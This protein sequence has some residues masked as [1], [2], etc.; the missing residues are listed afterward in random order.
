MAYR[1]Q[2]RRS[3]DQCH[4]KKQRCNWTTGAFQCERCI[5]LHLVCQK[6]RL[7]RKTY[8]QRRGPQ[9][10]AQ[11]SR[12]PARPA[13][14]AS[15]DHTSPESS[16]YASSWPI[17][18]LD[19]V[20][21]SLT[22]P[23]LERKLSGDLSNGDL[24]LLK[25]IIFD[26]EFLG[27]FIIG[28]SFY[29]P[30]QDCLVSH[31]L[32][33]KIA[34]LDA[35]MALALVSSNRSNSLPDGSELNDGLRRA[36]SA[37]STLRCFKVRDTQ[38]AA[39]CLVLGA[40]LLTFSLKLG[41]FDASTIC[42]QTIS[43]VKPVYKLMCDV[44]SE[45]LGFLHYL[46]LTD[47][48]ECLLQTKVPTLRLEFP[49]TTTHV[50]RYVGLCATLLP[51][52]HDICELS[53][54]LHESDGALDVAERQKA[55]E[56]SIQEWSPSLSD[57]LADLFT[58]TEVTH[59]VC[60]AKVMQTA[61]LLV[62]LR[63]RCPFGS[64]LDL[65]LDLVSTILD[66]LDMTLQA[67]GRV[68]CSVDLPLLIACLELQDEAERAEWLRKLSPIGAY[69]SSFYE[70]IKEK[71]SAIWT[72]RRRFPNLCWYHLGSVRSPTSQ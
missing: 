30:H 42:V 6:N 41:I 13:E 38:D 58:A 14:K 40:T 31:L 28:S 20:G 60:Q 70:Q 66:Q 64:Q 16:S 48:T 63:L 33:S 55:L 69:S 26:D 68:P 22:A 61:A 8:R 50:D 49:N 23:E 24:H 1:S 51:Y 18:R 27:Q 37:V 36:S 2:G 53:A 56:L 5:R 19:A 62:L 21:A 54:M 29:K 35:Y 3:C 9:S 34:L 45:E 47:I 39:V 15:N 12:P 71:L 10:S 43:L 4:S 44:Q 32:S 52:L 67:T 25:R 57:E 72:A 7:P 17:E 65:A 46:V 11:S 59:M